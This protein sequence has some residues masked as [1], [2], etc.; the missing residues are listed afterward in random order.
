LRGGMAKERRQSPRGPPRCTRSYLQNPG[1]GFLAAGKGPEKA[2]RAARGR[3]SAVLAIVQPLGRPR[4]AGGA[5]WVAAGE[6]GGWLFRIQ[7]TRRK[8][9]PVCLENSTTPAGLCC[10]EVP[11]CKTRPLPS[12]EQKGGPSGGVP[13]VQC[14]WWRSKPGSRG[15]TTLILA[16]C[17]PCGAGCVHLCAATLSSHP[18]CARMLCGA[19]CGGA[20][21]CWVVLGGARFVVS[22]AHAASIPVAVS[23]SGR[24]VP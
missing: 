15:R 1:F 2:A 6:A 24:G 3:D 10:V 20:G 12:H 9:P 22:F 4:R 16:R 19:R 13:G 23:S 11:Q 7:E 5:S 18:G 17:L 14:C 8:V 21:W